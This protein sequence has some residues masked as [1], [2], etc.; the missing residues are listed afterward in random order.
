MQTIVGF[1]GGRTAKNQGRMFIT[2]KPLEKERKISAD[3]VI[4][5]L[6]PQVG[7][8]FRARRC[9]CNRRRICGWAAGWSSAISVHASERRPGR[10]ERVGAAAGAAIC[11]RSRNCA[12]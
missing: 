10:I 12:T 4:D 6:R 9:S 5:R 2:L 7:R 8:G 11:G 3:Q 1:A